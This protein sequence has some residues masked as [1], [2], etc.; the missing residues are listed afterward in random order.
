M[1]VVFA[2]DSF[3]GSIPAQEA[4]EA[5][6][7]G[8]AAVRPGDDLVLR[9][10]ADG[11]EGTRAAFLAAIEG[12]QQRTTEVVG[13]D[14]ARHLAPWLMLPD[15]TAFIELAAASGIELLGER[16]LPFDAHTLGFGQLIAEAL[17]RGATRVLLGIGSSASTDAGTGMLRALGARFLD[18]D[19]RD[20]AL[21]LRGL[22]DLASVDLAGLTPL[23]Q[24]GVLVL[25]DVDNPLLGRRGAAHV[26]GP[27]KGLDPDGVQIADLL[28][29][30]V[31]ALLGVD[32]DRPGAGAAGG[33]G[34]A[35]QFW[36]ADV[37]A[38]ATEVARMVGLPDALDGADLVVT[39]EGKF[40]A[41]SAHGKVPANVADLAARAG[42]P[43]A[44]VAG[45]VAE[46]ADTASFA[47]VL[48]LTTLAGSP[49]AAMADAAR[50]LRES[51]EQLAR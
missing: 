43:V 1:R 48:S 26:F 42:V 41:S 23:P 14:G 40:D 36:G 30:R 24:R 19:G 4:A 6:A 12:T 7:E 5:L 33:T 18:S 15:D 11:G 13:P 34:Y 44:L 3:K 49:A 27:Q 9:P 45:V 28:L 21:G 47:T 39:G 37:G 38:G 25:S 31:A 22:Q 2:P 29:A 8:W 50:W 17:S 20:V 51:G 35:L 16:R 10:M 32:P 46:E